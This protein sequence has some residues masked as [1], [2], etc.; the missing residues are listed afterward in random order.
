MKREEQQKRQKKEQER[1]EQEQERQTQEQERQR[2]EEQRQ[3]EEEAERQ[4][5]EQVVLQW[6]ICDRLVQGMQVLLIDSLL[7]A[8][9]SESGLNKQLKDTV[10]NTKNRK[11][12]KA[13]ELWSP[14]NPTHYR[15]YFI[16]SHHVAG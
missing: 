12:K 11:L 10:M 1:Q 9:D 14:K 3:K 16:C 2:R 6:E 7:T 13:K 4:K 15:A 5:K 8:D